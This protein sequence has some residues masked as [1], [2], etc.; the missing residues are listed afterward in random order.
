MKTYPSSISEYLINRFPLPNDFEHF[1]QSVTI[2]VEYI[3]KGESIMT[4]MHIPGREIKIRQLRSNTN[5]ANHLYRFYV[6]VLQC[7][8]TKIEEQTY[9][10]TQKFNKT[11]DYSVKELFDIQLFNLKIMH[12]NQIVKIHHGYSYEK[13]YYIYKFGTNPIAFSGYMS[14]ACYDY[15]DSTVLKNSELKHTRVWDVEQFNL[16]KAY[17]YRQLLEMLLKN[18]C[19]SLWQ[20]VAKGYCDMRTITKSK[21]MKNRVLLKKFNLNYHQWKWLPNLLKI[22]LKADEAVAIADVWPSYEISSQISYANQNQLTPKEFLK[23]LAKQKQDFRIYRDYREML[24][25]LGTPASS[26]QTVYPRD[27]KKAHDDANDK[28]KGIKIEL[29]TKVYKTKILPAIEKLEYTNDKYA[30]LVPHNP[31]EI[32]MEGEALDHC[33]G[34]YISKVLAGKTIILFIRMIQ[35]TS[36]PFYTMEFQNGRISQIRGEGNQSA[37]EDV[38]EFA[39]LWQRKRGKQCKSLSIGSSPV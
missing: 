33:V 20:D 1:L 26:H 10:V 25:N 19:T 5:L 39:K 6:V 18:G 11:D 14:L 7:D 4:N 16:D 38:K 13:G 2:G 34:S 8:E 21:L 9:L 35:E 12:R 17:K 23:Y 22:G 3:R 32:L 31:E 24:T 15:I 30:V 27:L 36:R 29:E 37:P 28:L